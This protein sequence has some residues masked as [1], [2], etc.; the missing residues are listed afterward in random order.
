MTFCQQQHAADL[1]QVCGWLGASC[2]DDI[3]TEIVT[4]PIE[5][6][7]P[8]IREMLD[9][10]DEFP[11]DARRTQKIIKE[12]RSGKPAQ[13]V[14]I[15]QGDPDFFIME[16]RHRIVAFYLLRIIEVTVCYCHS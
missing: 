8:Q 2:P 16:G 1:H 15:E 9:T 14:Y 12:I 13:P 10:Y 5:E 4:R 3:R 7:L 6:F 11:E